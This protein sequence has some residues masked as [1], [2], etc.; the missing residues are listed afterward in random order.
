MRT[1]SQR[2]SC[3][4]IIVTHNSQGYLEKCMDCL[5]QQT[6]RP[7]Q[8]IIVDS[9]STDTAYLQRYHKNQGVTVVLC[10]ENIGFC[11]G[12]N[13]G[14]KEV[15]PSCDY[16]LL[17]NPDAFLTNRFLKEGID[18]LKKRSNHDVGVVTG[19]LLGYDRQVDQPTGEYDSTGVF[20]TWF[21]RWYDR[22]QGSKYPHTLYQKEEAVPAVCGALMFCRKK[23]LDEVLLDGEDIFDPA[24]YMYKEDIDLSL[25]LRRGGWKL[26]YVPSLV[27]YHCRGWK[28]ERRSV[29]KVFRLMSARNEMR[30]YARTGSP[31]ILYSALKYAAVKLFNY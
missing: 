23:A 7:Q 6:L 27:A 25:R 29:P 2:A 18:Y 14:Y 13:R 15:D 12:N 4:V 9:G 19:M 5:R 16:V 30:L 1:M 24:F 17:L 21:G 8:I 10:P 20:R 11:Q 26:S 22:G 31:Y 28:K 3:A